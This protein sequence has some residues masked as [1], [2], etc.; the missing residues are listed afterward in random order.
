MASGV[1]GV[2]GINSGANNQCPLTLGLL[3]SPYNNNDNVPGLLSTDTGWIF[4][5][6]MC[7]CKFYGKISFVVAAMKRESQCA[8][9][10]K[11]LQ[12]RGQ[13]LNDYAPCLVIIFPRPTLLQ[14]EFIGLRTRKKL[15]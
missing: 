15:V 5:G 11:L 14:I 8:L 6:F 13:N 1:G 9:R 10:F 4:L 7:F 2:I 3:S 12:G